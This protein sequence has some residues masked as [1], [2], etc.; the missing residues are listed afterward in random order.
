MRACRGGLTGFHFASDVLQH[1]LQQSI[2]FVI[3]STAALH[4]TAVEPCSVGACGCA[5]VSE[6]VFTGSKLR[7]VT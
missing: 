7:R 4:D 6:R 1:L 3:A 5:S 2:H